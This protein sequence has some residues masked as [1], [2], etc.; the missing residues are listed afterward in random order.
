MA[1]CGRRGRPARPLDIGEREGDGGVEMGAARV[2]FLV[3]ADRAVVVVDVPGN[4]HRG[5][6]T[7]SD[8]PVVWS[9]TKKGLRVLPGYLDQQVPET[10]ALVCAVGHGRLAVATRGEVDV[11]AVDLD[12][13]PDPWFDA[14]EAHD[15]VQLLVGRDLQLDDA[16]SDKAVADA[17]DAAARQGRLLGAV[18]DL[19]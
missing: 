11:V 7:P 16:P 9:F 17:L 12:D 6:L 19:D 2:S 8:D 15:G 5:A 1:G 18:V 13:L 10:D 4:G 14:A 3:L